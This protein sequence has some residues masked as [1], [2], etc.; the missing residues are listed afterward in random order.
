MLLTLKGPKAPPGSTKEQFD[1]KN[2]VVLKI[3]VQEM[4]KILSFLNGKS[5]NVDLIH[6]VDKFGTISTSTLKLKKGQNE[7]TYGLQVRI[8]LSTKFFPKYIDKKI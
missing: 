4:G 3:S 2:K 6:K 7:G 1:W 8:I 5:D